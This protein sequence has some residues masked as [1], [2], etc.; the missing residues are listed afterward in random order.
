MT[1]MAT[2]SAR[3]LDSVQDS[4]VGA[5]GAG[6]FPYRVVFMVAESLVALGALAGA[7]QLL[8]GSLTPPV[9]D[10]EPLG[11]RSWALPGLWL[12]ASVAIPSMGAAWLAWRRSA[13][14]PT[15]VLV[16]SGLLAVELI[17]QIP[18]VGPNMLQGVF[19][20]IAVSLAAA[21]VRSRRLGWRRSRTGIR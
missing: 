17:V 3:K 19:G 9:A 6:A 14:T 20:L 21:A 15:A 16:A 10:L 7:A 8:S 4:Q 18:F 11:L 12:F 1:A 13:S 2:V 5:R